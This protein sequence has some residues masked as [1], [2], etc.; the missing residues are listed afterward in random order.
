MKVLKDKL[1][2]DAS[3]TRLA[4][5][6]VVLLLLLPASLTAMAD[7]W[8]KD[9]IT[10]CEVW[11]ATPKGKEV[12]SWSGGCRDGK[13]SGTGAL[14]WVTDGKLT[15]R[16]EGDM[17]EG[18]A[19]G[20]GK[21]DFWLKDGFAHYEGELKDSDL[22]GKGVLLLPDKSRVEG[23]FQN[24]SVNGFVRY[25]AADG[26]SY[27]G[28][29][30]GNQADGKGYQIRPDKEEYYGDFK[31]GKRE[32]QGT[33][34]LANGDIYEGHF[35]A[36]EPSGEGKLETVEGGVYEGPFKT[37]QP[38]GEG[39]LT[40]PEGDVARGR[41]VNGEPDGKF[42]ITLKSGGTKEETWKKG[43]LIQ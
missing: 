29:V 12:I 39:V 16:F 36:G 34:L 32:G 35:E 40:T 27:A 26:G 17:V 38:D 8:L 23:V 28:E 10:G 24:N 41:V 9:P 25:T 4:L 13:V 22:R 1:K 19:Q 21:A 31:N 6:V 3:P 5:A 37:G 33:L 42:I 18:K 20:R 30:K 14:V 43:K 2:Q 15:G 11:N 7:E